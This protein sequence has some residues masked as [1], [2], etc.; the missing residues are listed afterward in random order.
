[1]DPISNYFNNSK[2]YVPGIVLLWNSPFELSTQPLSA[3]K[4]INLDVKLCGN[5]I[6]N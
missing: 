6:G 4:V 2:L 3:P 1:M 5:T